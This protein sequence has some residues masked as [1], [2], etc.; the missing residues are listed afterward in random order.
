M[1]AT[2]SSANRRAFLATS[3][4]SGISTLLSAQSRAAAENEV[5]RSFRVD[6]PEEALV[7]LR[8]RVQATRWPDT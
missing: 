7:D 6:V 3:A 4:A 2:L 8:R 1:P 5:I